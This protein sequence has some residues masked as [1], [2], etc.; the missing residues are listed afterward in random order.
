M[1]LNSDQQRTR[2]RASHAKRRKGSPKKHR[3][4]IRSR[5]TWWVVVG[6]A[7]IAVAL[8]IF[9]FVKVFV[10]PFSFRWKAIYGDGIEPDGFEV[11]G[12]DISH[13][14][15]RIN[16]DKLRNARI[17]GQPIRF[18]MIKAT[19]GVSLIDENFNE[20]F[21][22]VRQNGLIRGAYHFFTPDVDARR[23]ALFYIK[24]VHLEVGDLPPVLDVEK[25]GKLSD[26]QV[27]QEVHRWLDIV[28]N[29]FG[30]KP[31]IY[32]GYRFKMKYLNDG[33]FDE[34]PYWIAHYYVEQL[35]YKGAWTFWQY[36]DVGVI[37]G[38]GG[39]VDFN[40]FNGNIQQLKSITMQ[41]EDIDA[42]DL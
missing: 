2:P 23:Q 4:F 9:I 18:V 21:Y 32:T 8:Y 20:N 7:S 14:Q 37:D 16:W 28:E 5:H 6:S 39:Y 41:S 26:Q 33:T 31:I 19:E 35:E 38:I 15:D 27:R 3:S 12:I 34:Y 42:M 36:T 1:V 40:I 13:Y 25:E 22:Q 30:V 29:H 24:Q 11:R 10:T 17:N